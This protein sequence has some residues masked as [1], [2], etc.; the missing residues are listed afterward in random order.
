MTFQL[1]TDSPADAA[2][3]TETYLHGR[4]TRQHALADRTAFRRRRSAPAVSRAVDESGYLVVPWTI[5]GR[6]RMMGTSA[7]LIERP[8]RTTCSS[9]WLAARSIRYAVRHSTG[10]PAACNWRRT[11]RQRSKT[12]AWR[13]PRHHRRTGRGGQ[14]AGPDRARPRL[15]GRRATGPRLR[16]A[17]LSDPPSASGPPRHDTGLPPGDGGPAVRIWPPS[18]CR[19]STRVCLPFSWNTI[20]NEEATYRWEACDAAAGLGA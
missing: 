13:S 17:S 1:P 10:G 7:T 19:L 8:V 2:A 18:S 3:G 11:W 16:A 12:P 20:E 4:R 5:D 6:G 15:P 9:S 14:P